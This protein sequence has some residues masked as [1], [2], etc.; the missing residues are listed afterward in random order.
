MLMGHQPAEEVKIDRGG[1]NSMPRRTLMPT[2]IA[3]VIA[4]AIGA[5][6]R[7]QELSCPS[8]YAP[9]QSNTSCVP[10][11]PGAGAAQGGVA[12]QAQ[13][14][15]NRF[16]A[17]VQGAPSKAEGAL[18]GVL[19]SFGLGGSGAAPKGDNGGTAQGG[20]GGGTAQAGVGG[21]TAQAGVGGGTTNGDAGQH[22][23]YKTAS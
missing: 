6:A 2:T 8:G 19:N 23:H 7:A 20:V 4:V 15:L 1:K 3:V 13:Q 21:G 10:S 9:D 12:G 16:G 11:Q 22:P 17:A 5:G 18:G 14:L